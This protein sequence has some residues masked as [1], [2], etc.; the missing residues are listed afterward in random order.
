MYGHDHAERER[1]KGFFISTLLGHT[2]KKPR[3]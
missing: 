2:A 1:K 3:T